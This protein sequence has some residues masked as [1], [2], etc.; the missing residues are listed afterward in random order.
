LGTR[1]EAGGQAFY[2]AEN[3]TFEKTYGYAVWRI[4]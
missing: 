1:E 4:E 2:R 3:G